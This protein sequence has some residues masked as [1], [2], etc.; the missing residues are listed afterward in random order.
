MS[1]YTGIGDLASITSAAQVALRIKEDPALPEVVTLVEKI[2]S[3]SS[4]GGPSSPST[5][6]GVGLRRIVTPLKGFVAYKEHPWILP[7]FVSGIG[8]AIF[9]LGMIAGRKA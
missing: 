6:L 1:Y 5:E 3:L 9:A 7:A 4:G 8:F 2:K